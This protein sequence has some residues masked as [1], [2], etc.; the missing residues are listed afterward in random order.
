MKISLL[1]ILTFSALWL[2]PA[3][4]L[5][6]FTQQ[7]ND[8]IFADTTSYATQRAAWMY[9]F[10]GAYEKALWAF[11]QDGGGYPSLSDEQK[12]YFFSFRPTS[13]RDFILQRAKDEK[14]VMINE[15]HHQ[16][17]HR[18]FT[19]SLLQGLYDQGYRF[20]GLETLAHE[21]TLLNKRG[22]PLL[23]SGYYTQEPQFGNLVREALR[24][25][26][27]LFPYETQVRGDG[28]EREIQQA[29]NIQQMIE[30]HPE[31][32][33]L[34]HCGFDHINE[35]EG[36]HGWEKAMAGRVKEYTGIDPF[37]INQEI[38]T[39]R[40]QPEKENPFFKLV[41][42]L[43][44]ASVFVNQ[45]GDLFRGAPGDE[46]FDVRLFHPRTTYTGGRPAWLLLHGQRRMHTIDPDT[47]S[48]AYPVMIKA[49][50]ANESKEAVPVDII[51]W[52][53]YSDQKALVLRPGEYALD[54]SNLAG[55]TLK[56]MAAVP[57]H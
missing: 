2:P 4:N 43:A 23:S 51:E 37:T 32:K 53:N 56:I 14:I 5:Y 29:R 46:R 25:G 19:A 54:I 21:D 13:A 26:Y 28:K 39:E 36:M 8:S 33:F 30:A 49:Y 6:L 12:E 38:L 7:I 31:G 10:V 34:I 20:L 3:P 41:D 45:A 15:A 35:A 44:E 1:L 22:Y 52:Q 11:D 9:S 42:T 57:D 40:Y 48:I 27:E 17:M 24:I 47:I 18:V 16:P 55:D 50:Q